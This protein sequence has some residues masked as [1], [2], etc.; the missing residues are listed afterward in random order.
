MNPFLSILLF[1]VLAHACTFKDS[2]QRMGHSTSHQVVLLDIDG[3]R[4]MDAVVV[5]RAEPSVVW[6]NNGHGGF[7]PG[8]QLRGDEAGGL[9]AYTWAIARLAGT[10][11][12]A[13]LGDATT[14][15]SAN[16]L[17]KLGTDLLYTPAASP[18]P[19]TAVRGAISADFNEDGRPDLATVG[20]EEFSV[21]LMGSD[22]TMT[23]IFVDRSVRKSYGVATADVDGDGH[24]D[25]VVT[26]TAGPNDLYLGFGN[27]SFALRPLAFPG[28]AT[29][30]TRG[31]AL[32]DLNG[33][34]NLDAVFAN[35]ALGRIPW[36]TM[37]VGDGQGGFQNSG[38]VLE[39]K[40]DSYAVVMVDVD[41]DGDLDAI[42]GNWFDNAV[43][44]NPGDGQFIV[45][46]LTPTGTFGTFGMAVGDL[47]LSGYPDLFFVDN[48]GGGDGAPNTIWL[49]TC[50]HSRPPPTTTTT[51][52]PT[53][54]PVET[55]GQTV[56]LQFEGETPS[57]R[58]IPRDDCGRR[59][60][61][62]A[63]L[64]RFDTAVE[65]DAQGNALKTVD[66]ETSSFTY[67]SQRDGT[68]RF[69][70]RAHD[71]DFTFDVALFA[72]DAVVSLEEIMGNVTFQVSQDSFKWSI[73]MTQWPFWGEDVDQHTL[74]L[75]VALESN[76]GPII[77]LSDTP[78]ID[79]EHVLRYDVRTE[80]TQTVLR[81]LDLA[82]VDGKPVPVSHS[83]DQTKE[84]HLRA[85]IFTFPRFQTGIQFDPDISI[86]LTGSGDDD[87]GKDSTL[88]FV[89]AV[90]TICIPACVIMVIGVL[91]AGL[92]IQ[93]TRRWWEE[94]KAS[95]RGLNAINFDDRDTPFEAVEMTDL[96]E[97]SSSGSSSSSRASDEERI[98]VDYRRDKETG[99][100]FPVPAK[101]KDD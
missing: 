52:G 45:S 72:R 77:P 25:I 7:S 33:D 10:S 43:L 48:N 97:P 17:W 86:T 2:G 15:T 82:N 49:N 4:F 50:D 93:R 29:E 24:L 99:H 94:R 18:L 8:Q 28:S 40:V 38:Q 68:Y 42:L 35:R 44:T 70:T 74:E 53:F 84:G 3:D 85:L 98:P 23:K 6:K 39:S 91:A 16:R 75:R 79:Q 96:Q 58:L 56:V 46:K 65:R 63:L 95:R 66:F 36:S 90:A 87:C 64:V 67:V 55:E 27:G 32:G 69:D 11:T 13:L 41:L 20:L 101:D 61:E 80:H 59:H 81:V 100:L 21:L 71:T 54:P 26:R 88:S 22:E 34:G 76:D 37:W 83:L 51:T 92:V 60:E 73:R 89:M 19:A 5:N 1:A 47:T 57:A 78:V 12:I 14:S 9:N 31:V 62:S 30:W